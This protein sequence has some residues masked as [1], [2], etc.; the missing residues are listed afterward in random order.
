MRQRLISIIIFIIYCAI[1]IKVMVF[2][3]IPTIRIG[4]LM[5]NFAGTNGGHAPNFVPFLTI[6]PY[7]LGFKGWIIAGVNLAGNIALL[8]PIGLLAPLVYRR[9][10]WNASLALGVAAGLC[11]EVMKTVLRVGIFDID[12]VILNA[13]G[14]MIGYWAFII[15]AKWLRERKFIPIIVA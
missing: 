3:D 7:L 1:L 15:L 10:R 5:L 2:K 8:V 14:V 13:L 6:V 12:D 11:I 9:V 4:S